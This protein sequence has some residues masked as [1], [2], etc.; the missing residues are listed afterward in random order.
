MIRA[1]ESE[2]A[3]W[4]E[5]DI[6]P[7]SNVI[8]G[9]RGSVISESTHV[10]DPLQAQVLI[11]QDKDGARL[12]LVSL[13]LIGLGSLVSQQLHRA[14]CL[15]TGLDE[16]RILVNGSHTHS[17]PFTHFEHCALALEKPAS[18]LAYEQLLLKRVVRAAVQALQSLSLAEVRI[19]IGQS[20]IGINRR[21]KN[22]EGVMQMGP[23]PDGAYNRELLVIEARQVE[24]GR[25]CIAFSHACH[26][27]MNV[28]VDRTMLSADF[29]GAA[30]QSLKSQ[31]GSDCQVQFF[32][33]ACGDVR[34]RCL[35]LPEGGGFRAPQAGDAQR[36]GEELAGDVLR[37]LAIQATPERL[38]LQS[39]KGEFLVNKADDPQFLQASYWQEFAEQTSG[40]SRNSALYWAD[41]LSDSDNL[42]PHK[43]RYW[44]AG[45]FSLTR[46]LQVAW[47]GGEPL[48]EW[49]QFLR[50]RLN[51]D[52]LILWGYT[53]EMDGYLPMD[54]HLDE[55]GYEATTGHFVKGGP[56][57]TLAKGIDAAL[58]HC[59]DRLQ[60][61]LEA[62]S[63]SQK[64]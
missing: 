51:N 2:Y 62:T 45:L 31:L 10:N 37:T 57:P 46:S 19:R 25:R 12:M 34:P 21:L 32:Q 22:A 52:S 54:R 28:S 41:Y 42:P 8:L 5:I 63:T 61:I 56:E 53:G 29:P 4:S 30:R 40:A 6:T 49:Q 47:T 24:S 14:L 43:V 23:N 15:A 27:V 26:P 50:T 11:L 44:V 16:E 38:W 17:G 58:G 48:S 35:V 18:L 64:S 55:G 13:D 9:G 59:F 7:E 60:T 3:G 39:V 33:A 1:A 36:V 20:A